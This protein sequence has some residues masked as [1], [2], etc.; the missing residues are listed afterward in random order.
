M[1]VVIA[2]YS[3]YNTV[4]GILRGRAFGKII[5]EILKEC[6]EEQG[7]SEV[8]RM[9]TRRDGELKLTDTYIF[10]FNRLPLLPRTIHLSDWHHELIEEYQYRAQQSSSAKDMDT[11]QNI[12]IKSKLIVRGVEAKDM[13]A[14]CGGSLVRRVN[15]GKQHYA[16]DQKCSKYVS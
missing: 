10:T 1:N 4:K 7:V 15:C 2:A 5:E 9:Q 14:E 6:L 13:T 8:K 11:W 3:R 16:N 12:S